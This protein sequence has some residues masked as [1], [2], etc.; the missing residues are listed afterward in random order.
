MTILQ[1]LTLVY[2][3]VLGMGLPKLSSE[4]ALVVQRAKK[5][6]M[7]VSYLIIVSVT[8][9]QKYTMEVSNMSIVTM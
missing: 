3:G 4:Q 6:A 5:Y 8:E 9:I 2:R 7:E 1:L